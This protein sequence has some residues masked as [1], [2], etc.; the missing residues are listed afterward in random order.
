MSAARSG[1]DRPGK[2]GAGIVAVGAVAC[3]A[4]CAGPIIGA[5]SAV[6]IGTVAGTALFGFV[7]LLVG[8]IALLVVLRRRHQP[9]CQ[10]AL[11]GD[12]PVSLEQPSSRSASTGLGRAAQTVPPQAATTQATAAS[13]DSPNA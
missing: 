1:G 4:C 9:T 8:A 13:W 10:P 5:L 12:V 11:A 7:G 6:G 2:E 3:A